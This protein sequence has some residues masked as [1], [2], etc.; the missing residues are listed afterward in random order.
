MKKINN[1]L[2]KLTNP[3]LILSLISI[4]I[5]FTADTFIM[6]TTKQVKA[7][8]ISA[9]ILALHM[10]IILVLDLL[11]AIKAK[12]K[13]E[14]TQSLTNRLRERVNEVCELEQKN[15][16]L[17][18]DHDKAF[19]SWLKQSTDDLDRAYKAEKKVAILEKALHDLK[20]D[21]KISENDLEMKPFKQ[22][23]IE[24]L[25]FLNILKTLETEIGLDTGT[26]YL[27][28]SLEEDIAN[29]DFANEEDI[30]NMGERVFAL[31]HDI[32]SNA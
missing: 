3:L 1:I 18:E 31:K 24:R 2:K 30:K 9:S 16:K 12:A 13:E 29:A 17:V 19:D 32:E 21:I 23:E 27:V 10:L 15:A 26:N 7:V 28:R 11:I 25:C 6:D 5:I 20:H 8:A 22:G 14:K 4:V